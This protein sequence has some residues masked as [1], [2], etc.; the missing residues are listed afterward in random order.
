MAFS[1]WSEVFKF[2]NKIAGELVAK[3]P[4]MARTEA[5]KKAWKDA[6]VLAARKEYDAHKAKGAVKTASKKPAAQKKK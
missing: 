4:N 3:H 6:R 1:T 2:A 5:S